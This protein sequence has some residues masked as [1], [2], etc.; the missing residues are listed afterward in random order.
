MD[1]MQLQFNV[2]FRLIELI[3]CSYITILDALSHLM[4]KS[5]VSGDYFLTLKVSYG[6]Q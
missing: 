3:Q 6:Q 2:I 1:F 5:N 4:V